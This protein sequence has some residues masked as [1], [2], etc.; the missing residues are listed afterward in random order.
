MTTE[1]PRLPRDI[2]RLLRTKPEVFRSRSLPQP[3]IPPQENAIYIPQPRR[4]DENIDIIEHDTP[5]RT[6][7]RERIGTQVG[8]LTLGVT[9]TERQEQ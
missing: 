8:R 5:K 6:T 4:S 1:N 7:W 9:G 2:Q 3:D